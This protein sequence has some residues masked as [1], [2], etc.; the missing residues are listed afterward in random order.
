MKRILL[1]IALV[2]CSAHL[3][4]A[5]TQ[6][7]LRVN[8]LNPAVSY[9]MATGKNTTL[10]TSLGFGYNYSYPDLTSASI[11]GVQY[12]FAMFV[13]VQGRYYYNL[14]KREGN[15][16]R[17]D[18]NNGNFIAARMLY[19]GPGIS[20]ISSF[21]RFDNNS[22]AVGPTWGLQRTYGNRF[23][24]LFSTGP[25]YYFDTKGNGN[26]FPLNLELN[27]GINLN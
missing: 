10:D 26:I 12:L 18:R 4:D 13:D 17:T 7:V 11:S 22:F 23:N 25:I 27:L 15:G 5:Q 16:K 1:I 24:L 14:S 9:E 6:N 20:Q 8:F 2:F 21:D 19:T 3:S